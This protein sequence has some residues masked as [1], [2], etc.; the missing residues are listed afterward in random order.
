MSITYPSI[1]TD[2]FATKQSNN[3]SG[4]QSVT[5]AIHV[6]GTV[7]STTGGFKFPDGSVQTI[8]ATGGG[9]GASLQSAY[10]SGSS[11]QLA[12]NSNF[13]ITP[14]PGYYNKAAFSLLANK[15]S[16]IS[17]K[18]NGNL[19]IETRGGGS[20]LNINTSGSLYIL[21][22]NDVNIDS[23]NGGGINIGN[24][25]S[26]YDDVKIAVGNNTRRV[27][28]GNQYVANEEIHLL[29]GDNGPIELT[30]GGSVTINTVSGTL[31]SG[32]VEITGSVN[33]SGAINTI[34]TN[35]WNKPQV[36]AITVYNNASGS[37]AIDL[38]SSNN[39]KL[40]LSGN[41]SL[42][43]PTNI[44]EGQSGLITIVQ[45][46]GSYYTM[47]YG[48]FWKFPSGSVKDL[49]ATNGAIDALAYFVAS[50]SFAI[51]NMLGNIT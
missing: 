25:D 15:D 29:T 23:T 13:T 47:S 40:V 41:I 48:S 20:V 44:T 36:G 51:C 46:A 22:N 9:G 4:S 7:E 34:G 33:V 49:T 21:S 18:D 50:G 35:T 16:N 45:P 1:P 37:T 17:T 42:S 32:S 12:N 14:P 2:N 24:S 43:I 10:D 19:L 38:G 8:A 28:I 30:S 3:F 39:F 11:I 26:S 5:G 31:V 27:F 6:S